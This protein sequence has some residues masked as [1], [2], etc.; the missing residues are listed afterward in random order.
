MDEIIGMN[1]IKNANK[2]TIDWISKGYRKDGSSY[3][4]KTWRNL[5]CVLNKYNI[6]LKYNEVTKEMIGEPPFDDLDNLVTDIHTLNIEE[7]LNMSREQVYSSIY[8][9]ADKNSFNPFVD[10]IKENENTNYDLIHELFKCIKINDD[11]EENYNYYFTLFTK[12]CLNLVKMA[13]NTIDKEYRSEGILVFQG[14][15]GCRKTTFVQNLMPV[16]GMYKGDKSLNPEKTDSVIENTKYILVEWG[17]LDHTLKGEQSK[18]KQYITRSIDEYRSPYARS[19]KKYPRITSYIGTVNRKDFL[20]DETGSRRY[21]I[22]PVK[23][24]DFKKLK[25][26]DKKKLWGAVYSLWKSGTIKDYLEDDE[27]EKL[28]DMNAEYNFKN[29]ISYVIDEKIRWDMPKEEWC[30]YGITEIADYLMVKEKKSLKIE[31][32]K[33]GLEYK[34]YRIGPKLKKGFCIPRFESK[35]YY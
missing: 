11:N 26:I 4:L 14:R 21:W 16:K 30:V 28:N 19:P 9:I 1:N 24:F 5:E 25:A 3:P 2:S 10:M 31:L 27:M 17:E 22:I 34:V 12:W 6:K 7:F 20:K 18:L 15:Q 8:K 33:K 35:F 13:N 29:D 23:G 32:E